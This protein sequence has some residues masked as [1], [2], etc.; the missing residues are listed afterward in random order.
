MKRSNISAS[1]IRKSGAFRFNARRSSSE[2]ADISLIKL[3]NGPEKRIVVLR[4]TGANLSLILRKALEWNEES[5]SG[6]EVN[7]R[8][9]ASGLSIPLHYVWLETGL[10]VG[11]VMVGVSD[12]LPIDGV[13]MLLGNDLAGEKVVPEPPMIENP[14]NEEMEADPEKA[15]KYEFYRMGVSM[16]DNEQMSAGLTAY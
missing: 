5:Y 15:R 14:W 7:V 9:L 1:L 10:V 2:S 16:K 11:K 3:E 13:D 12:E 8:G 6:E 4:D